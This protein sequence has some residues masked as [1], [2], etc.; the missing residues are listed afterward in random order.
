MLARVISAAVVGV[1][2]LMVQVEVDLAQGLPSFSTVGLP[3]GAVREAKDRVRAAIRNSG[4]EFPP[5]RITVNLAPAAVKKEGTG[6]DLPIAV[7]I[8]AAG[9][10]FA[11]DQLDGTVIT[12]ELSLD[13]SVRPVP[14]VLPMALAA[15]MGSGL[16][17]SNPS[18]PF[19]TASTSA[20]RA[21]GAPGQATTGC[22]RR[23]VSRWLGSTASRVAVRRAG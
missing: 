22:S 19:L 2:G 13:G 23:G 16:W 20:S 17:I 9:G 1:D 4:Y 14:G 5:R 8:L 15:S 18:P 11:H 3:E 6:Y 21:L 12:G 10:L 7:G